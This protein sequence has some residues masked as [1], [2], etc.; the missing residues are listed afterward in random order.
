VDNWTIL[1]DNHLLAID[2]VFVTESA[3]AC[4]H[5]G[6]GRGCPRGSANDNR[7]SFA[8]FKPGKRPNVA[9][10]CHGHR[11]T[12]NDR[13]V[14][15]AKDGKF[16]VAW[17]QARQ[18]GRRNSTPSRQRA[19][20]SPT[21]PTTAS[22]FADSGVKL[23]AAA[24]RLVGQATL[25]SST[26]TSSTS[27]IRNQPRPTI[28]ASRRASEIGTA[29]DGTVTAFIGEPSAGDRRKRRGG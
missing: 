8:D 17:G 4:H 11:G 23:V 13:S 6:V 20:T 29:K 22:R 18:G 19:S 5:S 24:S 26:L 25:R 12:T 21:A 7:W 2:F 15:F 3:A 27:P 10:S 9:I 28:C 14:N 1:C 16:I